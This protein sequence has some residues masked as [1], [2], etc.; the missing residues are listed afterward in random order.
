MRAIFALFIA[1][2]VTFVFV[3]T[4]AAATGGDVKASPLFKRSLDE[5]IASL[6]GKAPRAGMVKSEAEAMPTGKPGCP[7]PDAPLTS[8]GQPTCA[9]TCEPTQCG[10][11]CYTQ[12]NTC[13]PTACGTCYQT[14]ASTCSGATCSSTC[15]GGVCPYHYIWRGRNWWVYQGQQDYNWNQLTWPGAAEKR[16]QSTGIRFLGSNPP[17]SPPGAFWFLYDGYFE[18]DAWYSQPVTN[19]YDVESYIEMRASLE[20]W[21][22]YVGVL[23]SLS[24]P[25]DTGYGH[26]VKFYF[27]D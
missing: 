14:C 19:I 3:G 16:S 15:A 4:S 21:I 5:S 22:W 10:G 8:Y 2:A 12:A 23:H 9:E 11:E 17:P 13:F 27:Y 25:D 20:P 6:E 24:P 7:E 26:N 1:L 18:T